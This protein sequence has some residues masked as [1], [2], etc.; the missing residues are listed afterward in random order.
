MAFAG[1]GWGVA[2]G[3]RGEV[4]GEPEGMGP[5][6]R[7]GQRPAPRCPGAAVVRLR[8]GG[9]SGC[10]PARPKK[11]GNSL[12]CGWSVKLWVPHTGEVG[13]AGLALVLCG[14][15]DISSER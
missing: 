4:G 5:V 12:A 8:V 13:R 6:A 9:G 14:R 11:G 15:L 1:G 10:C 3:G 2:H 7:R